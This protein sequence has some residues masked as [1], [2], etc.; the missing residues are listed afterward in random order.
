MGIGGLAPTENN[1]AVGRDMLQRAAAAKDP[2]AMRLLGRVY[3]TGEL[4]MDYRPDCAVELLQA[5]AA[6]NDPVALHDLGML[7]VEGL[8][9]PRDLEKARQ[10]MHKSADLGFDDARKYLRRLDPEPQAHRGIVAEVFSSLTIVWS[11]M[12]PVTEKAEN[13]GGAGAEPL[14][15]ICIE[16]DYGGV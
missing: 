1:K 10:L 9:V 7:H 12:L 4:N 13:S 8:V 11:L 14:R 2:E 15:G 16:R 5:S 3:L 6:M